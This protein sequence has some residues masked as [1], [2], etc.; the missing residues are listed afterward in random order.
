VPMKNHALLIRAFAAVRRKHPCRLV[1]IGDGPLRASLEDLWKQELPDQPVDIVPFKNDILEWMADM[2]VFTLPSND[3]EGL[4]M[5]LLEA[6]LLE[7]AVVC[8]NSGGIPEVIK[9]GRN[10]R[11]FSMGD[12]AGLENALGEMVSQPESRAAQGAALRRDV[13]ANNDMRAT[14]RLY[15]G[16]YQSILE[17]P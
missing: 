9:D 1:I 7:K 2:D 3:G 4:P 10:G 14:H 13:L 15:L 12:Q 17:I 6:G 11:L 5:A 16:L 8:S